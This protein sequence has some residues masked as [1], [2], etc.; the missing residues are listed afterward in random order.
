MRHPT[1]G[2]AI[3]VLACSIFGAALAANLG[4]LGNAP[5]SR[6][7]QED[8]DILYK[9][10]VD[11]LDKGADGVRVGW[12]NPKTDAAGTLRPLDT[13]KGPA[14][15]VCRHLQIDNRAGGLRNQTVLT[16]CETA[17]GTWKAK[18]D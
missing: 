18:T 16:L 3:L 1:Y 9:A 2:A 12:E 7:N 17:D 14:G 10:A 13:F 5:I 8:V 4:F 6:M 15:E 11:V